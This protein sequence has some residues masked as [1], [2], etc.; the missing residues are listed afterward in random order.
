MRK[1]PIITGLA[2]VWLITT[3]VTVYMFATVRIKPRPVRLVITAPE[4]LRFSGSYVAD[5]V[6]N[7]V[8]ALA[9]A[10]ISLRDRDVTFECKRDGGDAEFRVAMYVD[11]SCRT[12]TVSD[13]KNG[14]RGAVRYAANT[15]TCW[16]A[17]FD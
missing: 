5:G 6:T 15:E 17:P 12:S 3:K 14:V 7:S 4:G 11:D 10:T 8:S 2:L 13:K 16:A 9:P 1:G